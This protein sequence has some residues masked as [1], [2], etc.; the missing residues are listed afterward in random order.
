[1]S[2][3]Q[4]SYQKQNKN[5]FFLKFYIFINVESS[6]DVVISLKIIF[7]NLNIIIYNLHVFNDYPDYFLI[8]I[9]ILDCSNTCMYKLYIN[10]I[11]NKIF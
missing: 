3:M 2:F 7:M 9:K 5:V 6:L 8:K 10:K 4:S 11:L 1:M